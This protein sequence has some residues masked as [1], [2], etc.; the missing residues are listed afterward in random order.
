MSQVPLLA[1][2]LLAAAALPGCYLSHGDE[3][4]DAAPDH[5]DGRD[6]VS[7]TVTDTATSGCEEAQP[8]PCA[9]RLE[10]STS[11]YGRPDQWRGYRCTA[12]AETGREAVYVFQA[13]EN[14]LVQ[15]RLRNLDVDL[16]LLL[17][18]VCA[19]E[20]CT[21]MSSTPFTRDE[22]IE[23][24]AEAGTGYFVVVDGYDEAAGN[25]TIEVDCSCGSG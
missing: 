4:E 24:T 1:V 5:G 25:Y 18:P 9:S 15:V 6:G 13:A 16:D 23:F 20:A 2:T 7:D 10:G 17:L 19:P 11:R 21:A 8:L 22:L 3:H 12:R 14:C